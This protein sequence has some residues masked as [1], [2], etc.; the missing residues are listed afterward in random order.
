V[1]GLREDVHD[2]PGSL[3]FFSDGLTDDALR[4]EVFFLAYHL[5]W[6]WNELMDMDSSERRTYARLLAEQI[7]RENARIEEARR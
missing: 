1:H 6:S 3:A 5:H 7:E 4:N 2:E